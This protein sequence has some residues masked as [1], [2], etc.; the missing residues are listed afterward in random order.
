MVF[1]IFTTSVIEI[2]LM[3]SLAVGVIDCTI[4]KS[5]TSDEKS[6]QTIYA[7]LE[8]IQKNR[9]VLENQDQLNKVLTKSDKK[10][11]EDTNKNSITLNSIDTMSYKELRDFLIFLQQH[12]KGQNYIEPNAI[13]EEKQYIKK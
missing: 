4:L 12:E 11:S 6:L 3:L 5:V 10:S 8:D 9:L 7:S 13:D 1:G 2:P